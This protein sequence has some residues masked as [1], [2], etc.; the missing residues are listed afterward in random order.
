MEG[1]VKHVVLIFKKISEWVPKLP[2]GILPIMLI[3][4]SVNAM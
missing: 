1:A 4:L 3:Q 2:V